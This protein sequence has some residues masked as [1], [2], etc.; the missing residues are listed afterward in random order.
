MLYHLGRR[1]Q[2]ACG[3]AGDRQRLQGT[4]G[5]KHPGM[6][7]WLVPALEKLTPDRLCQ[8]WSRR[9]Q[10]TE[11]ALTRDIQPP[12]LCV[13]CQEICTATEQMD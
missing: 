13:S 8:P 10:G 12:S 5:M 7:K 1:R 3:T 9:T 2:F 6:S 4:C 11:E